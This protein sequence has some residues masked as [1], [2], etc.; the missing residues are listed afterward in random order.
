ME[1]SSKGL[2]PATKTDWYCRDHGF[3]G[4]IALAGYTY[5]DFGD[6]KNIVH[7]ETHPLKEKND[8]GSSSTNN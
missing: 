4:I 6:C 3:V 1:P 8:N 7:V 2:R 5:C